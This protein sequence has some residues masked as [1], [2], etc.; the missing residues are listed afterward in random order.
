MAGLPPRPFLF[1]PCEV[2]RD[3][4]DAFEEVRRRVGVV[5]DASRQFCPNGIFF[6]AV[7][8]FHLDLY[9]SEQIFRFNNRLGKHD[10][11]RFSKAL[12]M[13]NGKRLTWNTL[14]GKE[15]PSA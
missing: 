14:T 8:P 13:V 7:E 12:S 9:L 1:R 4:I 3:R 6:S 11:E 2:S 10:G 5:R 15:G